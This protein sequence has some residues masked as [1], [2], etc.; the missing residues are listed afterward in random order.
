[1]LLCAKRG[2]VGVRIGKRERK[3]HAPEDDDNRRLCICDQ[4]EALPDHETRGED[5]S[6]VEDLEKDLWAKWVGS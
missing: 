6:K 5:R 3:D 2:C 1:M 4:S